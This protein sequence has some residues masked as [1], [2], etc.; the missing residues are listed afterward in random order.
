M[1][2]AKESPI[3]LFFVIFCCVNICI[4]TLCLAQQ[5]AASDNELKAAYCVEVIKMSLYAYSNEML[6]PEYKTLHLG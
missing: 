4:P 6:N 1:L 5:R 2:E 3:K